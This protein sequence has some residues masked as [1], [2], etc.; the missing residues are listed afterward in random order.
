MESV[1]NDGKI[2]LDYG[3][4]CTN[5]VLYLQLEYY[6]LAAFGPIRFYSKYPG[7]LVQHAWQRPNFVAYTRDRNTHS[8][9]PVKRLVFQ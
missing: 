2:T 5:S 7:Y 3:I 1:R 9:R 8:Y 6:R 4:F